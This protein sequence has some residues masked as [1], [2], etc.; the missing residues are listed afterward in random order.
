[1]APLSSLVFF[2]PPSREQKLRPTRIRDGIMKKLL[3][4][5]AAFMTLTVTSC[6]KDSDDDS[7]EPI[8]SLAG[9]SWRCMIGSELHWYNSDANF[10][11][12]FVSENKF[13][14]YYSS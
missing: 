10:T 2:T 12:N 14:F 13:V 4:V 9:T 7:V 3:L 1:M 6:S 5:I 11:V 8:T